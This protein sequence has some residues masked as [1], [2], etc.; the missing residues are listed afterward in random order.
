MADFV[1]SAYVQRRGLEGG[2]SAT[3]YLAKIFRKPH[4][5]KENW[6]ERGVG[7]RVQNCIVY[8]S[9]DAVSDSSQLV[10]PGKFNFLP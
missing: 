4:E 6:M 8:I 2:G 1:A 7:A 9:T 10:H 3:Y 5:N